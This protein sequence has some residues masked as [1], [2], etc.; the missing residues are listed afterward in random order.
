[1]NELLSKLRAAYAAA[2][3]G[4]KEAITE[5]VN[6]LKN[7]AAELETLRSANPL[8]EAPA[9]VNLKIADDGTYDVWFTF[10]GHSREALA[11]GIPEMVK[12]LQGVGIIASDE[13]LAQRR[14]ERENTRAAIRAPQQQVNP[15]AGA[16]PPATNGQPKTFP[17]Q[18]LVPSV[19]EGKTYFKVKGGQFTKYGVKVWP[20]V[21]QEVGFDLDQLDATQ[22]YDL[23][24]YEAIYSIKEDGAP[25]KVTKLV[26]K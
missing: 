22:T 1:M 17:A 2:D 5:A 11:D 15:A 10:R 13:A 24:R 9:S 12:R 25:E 7:Q 8:P 26:R 3:N 20:E 18:T 6:E 16:N 21:L 4:H 14:A 23:S 19:N